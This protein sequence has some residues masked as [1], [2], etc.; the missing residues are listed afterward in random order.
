MNAIYQRAAFVI[1]AAAGRDAHYGLPGISRPRRSNVQIKVRI[2]STTLVT[3]NPVP[4]KLVH[5]S[6][7]NTRAWTYQEGLLARR[8]LIFTDDQ[9]L[10]ECKAMCCLEGVHLPPYV[11]EKRLFRNAR[12]TYEVGGM[13]Q[14]ALSYHTSDAKERAPIVWDKINVYLTKSLTYESDALNAIIGILSS[15][16]NIQHIGG[17]PYN[18]KRVNS[19]TKLARGLL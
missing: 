14:K 19:Q 15:D 9:M 8:R 11:T 4:S 17:V 5:D 13:I 2:N 16:E 7:W 6:H 3:K 12:F 18:A 10:F 1:I